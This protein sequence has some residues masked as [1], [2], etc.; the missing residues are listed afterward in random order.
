MQD[1]FEVHRDF[2]ACSMINVQKAIQEDSKKKAHLM[3]QEDVR[4]LRRSKSGNHQAL[5]AK[6]TMVAVKYTAPLSLLYAL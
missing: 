6:I 2:S 4:L 3:E 1:L 5:E